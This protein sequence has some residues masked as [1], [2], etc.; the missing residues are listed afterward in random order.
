[1]LTGPRRRTVTCERKPGRQKPGGEGVMRKGVTKL[2]LLLLSALQAGS[3]GAAGVTR[4]ENPVLLSKPDYHDFGVGEDCY[5][6]LRL[7]VS[8]NGSVTEVE[9]LERGFGSKEFIDSA[10]RYVKGYRFK[11]GTRDG[12]PVEQ[13]VRQTFFFKSGT[14]PA[15]SPQFVRESRKVAELIG[16]GDLA[17]GK[18]HAEWMLSEV[19]RTRY[20]QLTLQGTLA[21]THARIGDYGRA[22]EALRSATLRTKPAP[23]FELHGKTPRNSA[24]DYVLSDRNYIADLLELKLRLAARQGFALEG[25][26]A[27]REL[28]GLVKIKRDDPRA[29]IAARLAASLDGQADLVGIVQLSESGSWKHELYRRSFTLDQVDGVVK[30]IRLSCTEESRVLEYGQGLDWTVPK[31][32]SNC[33]IFISGEPETHLRIVEF[34]QERPAAGVPA[35]ASDQAAIGASTGE[36]TVALNPRLD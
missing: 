8:N 30:E 21:Q 33:V 13:Y 9:V 27:F 4:V 14:H 24:A 6:V 26:K 3:I 17:G 19:V 23:E 22:I 10:I 31:G 35:A 2:T 34:A 7:T 29:Q 20:E 15:I 36:F 12:V 11:P 25:L 32:W 28:D 16:S 5:F 18:F 1:M